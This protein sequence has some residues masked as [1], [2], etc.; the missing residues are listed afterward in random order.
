MQITFHGFILAD[1]DSEMLHFKYFH[2]K[3]IKLYH[4]CTQYETF[5]FL[6]GHIWHNSWWIMLQFTKQF[7]T[8][9]HMHLSIEFHVSVRNHIWKQTEDCINA[10][11]S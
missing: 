7:I 2:N 4:L 9:V 3:N 6:N 8:K 1:S 11:T 5:W 10:L